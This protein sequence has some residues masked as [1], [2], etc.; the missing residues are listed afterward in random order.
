MNRCKRSCASSQRIISLA[1]YNLLLHSKLWRHNCMGQPTTSALKIEEP[2]CA[3]SSN[4][5][6]KECCR[7]GA[8]NLTAAHMNICKGPDTIP[9][10]CGIKRHFER[11][12][13]SKQE[14]RMNN[15][16]KSRQFDKRS[17][18]G[19]IV[20]RVDYGEDEGSYN[21]DTV[22]YILPI[23]LLLSNSFHSPVQ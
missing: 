3:I 7:C 10:Y 2:V 4:Q 9:N 15:N 20:Q 18:I 1:H 21:E 19:R 17:H 6:E 23:K 13:N 16:A 5:N 11:C 14:D 22:P 8:G 12:S